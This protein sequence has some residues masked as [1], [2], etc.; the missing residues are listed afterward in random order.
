MREEGDCGTVSRSKSVET[1][2]KVDN[3]GGEHAV[4]VMIVLV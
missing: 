2:L 1:C 4:M 3:P